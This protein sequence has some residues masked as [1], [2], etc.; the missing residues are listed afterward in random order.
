MGDLASLWPALGTDGLAAA[1]VHLL[2]VWWEGAPTLSGPGPFPS[3]SAPVGD[4]LL[5]CSVISGNWKE[6]RNVMSPSWEPSR[7]DGRWQRQK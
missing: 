5:I 3:L 1:S 4:D 2:Q 7:K 6:F